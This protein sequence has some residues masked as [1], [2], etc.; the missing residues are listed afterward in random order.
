MPLSADVIR[1]FLADQ[2]EGI[3]K[4][5]DLVRRLELIADDD[6]GELKSCHVEGLAG[7]HAG[8]QLLILRHNLG[9]RDVLLSGA[10]QIAVDLIGNDPEIVFFHDLC[11]GRELF[12]CPHA[13]GGVVRI[14]ENHQ[15]CLGVSAASLKILEIHGEMA[16]IISLQR[17]RK[18][19]HIVI[20]AGMSK[21][22][23]GRGV[24]NHLLV[25]LAEGFDQLE[26]RGDDARGEGELILG[27]IPVIVIPAP[28]GEGLI[29]IV[30]INAGVA[31][32]PPVDPV[33]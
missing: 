5:A 21:I 33:F 26:E 13:P 31:E 6:V 24:D 18:E 16:G 29:V 12:R 10:D 4:S 2:G 17:R 27:N 14:A 22:A 8:D 9:H 15:L 20:L 32:D 11:H 28:F 7:G 19:L 3:D 1:R 30:I 23:V 25:L